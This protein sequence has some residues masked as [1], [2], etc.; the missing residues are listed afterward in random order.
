MD[1]YQ[2]ATCILLPL[3]LSAGYA[4]RKHNEE[5]ME[6]EREERKEYYRFVK[7]NWMYLDGGD[8]DE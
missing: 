7:E 2:I 8:D 1:M 6:R 4:F 5:L 3:A